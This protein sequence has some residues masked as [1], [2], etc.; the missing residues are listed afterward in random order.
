MGSFKALQGNLRRWRFDQ[1]IVEGAQ[2]WQGAVA[3]VEANDDLSPLGR[4]SWR[5][6]LRMRHN[7]RE[8][9]AMVVRQSGING[10]LDGESRMGR[11][12]RSRGLA[13]KDWTGKSET[14]WSR[15]REDSIT[16]G[17][18]GSASDGRI[19]VARWGIWP[20]RVVLKLS[21][22]SWAAL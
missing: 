12:A 8:K 4:S 1:R 2:H 20:P 13:W 22:A 9:M 16:I 11:G 7:L 18:T 10:S 5:I 3:E 6:G 21:Q 19:G 14:V 15:R 17:T